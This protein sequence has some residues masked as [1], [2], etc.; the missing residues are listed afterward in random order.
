VATACLTCGHHPEHP[1][2]TLVKPKR[3]D[4]TQKAQVRVQIGSHPDESQDGLAVIWRSFWTWISRIRGHRSA[5]DGTPGSRDRG[6]L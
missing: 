5:L 3:E 6:G 1:A 2:F 4:L